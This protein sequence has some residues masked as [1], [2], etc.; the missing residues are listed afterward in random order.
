M[1]STSLLACFHP[2]GRRSL[3]ED[4]GGG[5]VRGI[6][7]KTKTKKKKGGRTGREKRCRK[8]LWG[9]W[10]DAAVAPPLHHRDRLLGYDYEDMGASWYDADSSGS[11]YSHD[12]D[13]HPH[14]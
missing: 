5:V 9:R 6:H 1:G 11:D 3:W 2:F 13:A 7:A 8:T 4:D 10:R 12:E 14:Y